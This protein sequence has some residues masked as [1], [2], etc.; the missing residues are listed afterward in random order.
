MWRS[1]SRVRGLSRPSTGVVC[2]RPRFNLDRAC[3]QSTARNAP[4]PKKKVDLINF[5]L[6]LRREVQK[7][8]A[9]E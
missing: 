4:A 9:S 3:L 7:M 5:C 8:N 2:R 6:G 1:G